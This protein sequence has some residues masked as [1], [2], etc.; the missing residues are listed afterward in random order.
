VVEVSPTPTEVPPKDL[1]PEA[2]SA[3]IAFTS[4]PSGAEVLVNGRSIGRTPTTWSGAGPGKAYQVEYRKNGYASK[5]VTVRVPAGGGT[6]PANAALSAEK[7]EPGEL[8]VNVKGGWGEVWIDGRRVDT[9]PLKHQL[10]PGTYKVKVVNA[11]AGLDETRTV[12]VVPGKTQK[13][14]FD[15]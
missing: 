5:A 1:P 15:L 11:D 3:S 4:T 9:T 13:L 10:A 12:T 8:F 6:V 2:V 14:T 7:V